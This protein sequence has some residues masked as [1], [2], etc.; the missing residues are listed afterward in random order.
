MKWLFAAA[1]LG[2]AFWLLLAGV[3][4]VAVGTLR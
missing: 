2:L 4:L 1:L 3:V